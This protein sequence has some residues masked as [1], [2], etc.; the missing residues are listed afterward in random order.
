MKRSCLLPNAISYFIKKCSLGLLVLIIVVPYTSCGSKNETPESVAA[1]WCDL[2]SKY[3]KATDDAGR[4]KA[5]AERKKFEKDME[6]KYQND[7]LMMME[8]YKMVEA[9]EGASEGRNDKAA[10]AGT[11]ADTESLLPVAY[12][13]A[14]A[15]ADA[16]CTLIEKSINAAKDNNNTE[17][18]KIVAAKFIF[19]KN[20]EESY[21]DNV[22]RRDSIF[23]LIE[24]CVAKEVKFRSQ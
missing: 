5:M 1:A 8:I 21:K 17:L 14:V 12:Q 20:M 2:N 23:G 18:N 7:T 15:A 16:Y 6:A 3:T 10:P 11:N 22:E 24:P 9:C 4:E 19:E 13:D